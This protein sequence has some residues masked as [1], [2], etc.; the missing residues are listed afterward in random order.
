MGYPFSCGVLAHMGKLNNYYVALVT[1]T[2]W[3]IQDPCYHC[4]EFAR[5]QYPVQGLLHGNADIHHF[6]ILVRL[7]SR[8]NTSGSCHEA[9]AAKI[10]LW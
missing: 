5:S 4:R 3:N 7:K 9:V 2:L 8:T 6:L 10:K 1:Q